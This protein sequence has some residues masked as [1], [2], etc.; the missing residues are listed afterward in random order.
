MNA[1]NCY[2]QIQKKVTKTEPAHP[3]LNAGATTDSGARED[4]AA[5][6]YRGSGTSIKRAVQPEEI[7]R[8]PQRRPGWSS[9]LIKI[10]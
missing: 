4:A 3:K 1:V 8:Q 10:R 2:S 9:P 6:F 7:V 5:A